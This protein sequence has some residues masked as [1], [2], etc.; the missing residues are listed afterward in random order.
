MFQ[1]YKS[2]I[3]WLRFRQTFA[4][5]GQV[6]NTA[7]FLV[8]PSLICWLLK[9]A[10]SHQNI[11]NSSFQAKYVVVTKTFQQRAEE[12]Y[13]TDADLMCHWKEHKCECLCWICF[14]PVVTLAQILDPNKRHG[15]KKI[16]K[17]KNLWLFTK[18]HSHTQSLG[19]K[20]RIHKRGTLNP[21]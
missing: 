17:K 20:A 7:Y 13:I 8:Q 1:K 9:L 19:V 16:N 5:K 18:V 21:R 15:G 14:S 11:D 6:T 2:V 12:W 4:T 3:N 10:Q